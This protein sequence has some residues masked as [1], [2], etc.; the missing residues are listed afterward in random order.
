MDFTISQYLYDPKSLPSIPPLWNERVA[1]FFDWLCVEVLQKCALLES[2][3]SCAMCKLIKIS[4][5]VSL[6]FRFAF[7][8]SIYIFRDYYYFILRISIFLFYTY[9]SNRRSFTRIWDANACSCRSTRTISTVDTIKPPSF[10]DD[11]PQRRS[12]S[13]LYRDTEMG[14]DEM[15]PSYLG[16]EL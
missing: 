14:A 7:H 9:L 8:L 2:L 4:S 3:Q 15:L 6:I 5:T 12:A 13:A 10:Y 11:R 1:L 16:A